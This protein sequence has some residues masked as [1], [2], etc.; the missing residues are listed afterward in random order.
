MKTI[1]KVI[2]ISLLWVI[3]LSSFRIMG[4]ASSRLNMAHAWLTG[5]DEITLPADYKPN[6]RLGSRI[7]VVG[8]GGKRYIPYDVGQSLL[9]IPGDWLGIQLHKAFPKQNDSYFREI[10]ARWVTFIPLNVALIVSCFWLLKI[11]DFSEKVAALGSLSLLVSTTVMKYVQSSQQ[12]NQIL[13]FAI[14]GYACVIVATKSRFQ[15][16]SKIFILLSGLASGTA[17]LIRKTSIVH[18]FT[19]FL[20]TVGCTFLIKK[21]VLETFKN[22]C[23]WALGVLPMVLIGRIFDYVRFGVFWTTGAS[24][25]AK[26]LSTDPIYNGLP[27]LPANFP[28]N[29]P[30]WVGIWGTLF[31][32]AKSIFIYDPLLIPC[33]VLGVVLWKKLSSYIKLYFIANTFNL[34][35]HLALYSKLDFWHGDAAWGARYH[36]TS[37]HLLLI[38]LIA[39]LVQNL[40][41]AKG[42][43]LWSIKLILVVAIAVQA[44]SVVLRPSAESKRIYFARPESFME[45]RLAE[46]VTN[47]GCLINDSFAFDCSKRLALDNANPLITK[48]ALWPFG[49][50]SKR[51]LVFTIWGLLLTF[52]I[53]AT[54]RLCLIL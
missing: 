5:T 21:N 22:T 45:F 27:K 12:N 23:L 2:L 25:G 17:F 9:M 32:P 16:K 11:F 30:P 20:F 47:I 24:L 4:D 3:L 18:L 50:T 13:L 28:F 35:L 6:S 15:K 31:S 39:L 34:L 44:P 51:Y 48:A 42:L 38:P 40:L 33:L 46:R 54:F 37:V 43:Y 14:L 8:R 49:F 52:A 36:V 29:N 19:I 1:S 26:Q 10:V 41:S 7:G 53:I